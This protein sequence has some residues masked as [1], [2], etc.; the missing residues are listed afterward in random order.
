MLIGEGL[1]ISRDGR[2]V[3]QDVNF[4]VEPGNVV[5]LAGS[6]ASGKSTLLNAIV[7]LIPAQ[8]GR[9][10]MSGVVIDRLSV[11]GRVRAGIVFVP[12]GKNVFL[13]LTVLE[14]LVLAARTSKRY[15]LRPEI[16]RVAALFLGGNDLLHRRGSDL[17]GGERQMVCL[18]R[19][20]LQEPR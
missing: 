13:N 17:S 8:S 6:N 16:E 19:A 20:A 4:Q 3:L 5:A 18:V 9:L 2:A 11:H 14:Q 7:G 10:V 1:H 15:R 12:Q